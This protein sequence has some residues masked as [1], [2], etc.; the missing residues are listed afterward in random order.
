MT[1]EDCARLVGEVAEDIKTRAQIRELKQR[2]RT[3]T[4]SDAFERAI[5]LRVAR[6]NWA[7]IDILPVAEAVR[8]ALRR[9]F[10]ALQ[11]SRPNF[12]IN[13]NTYNFVIA[14]KMVT[15]RRFPC[16][17][18]DWEISG[19][20]LSWMPRLPK[21]DVP[22]CLSYLAFRMK[23]R[24]PLFF[25]HVAPPPRSRG[26]VVAREVLKSWYQMAKSLELQPEMRG[27][28]ACAW[29]LDPLALRDHPHLESLS[30]PFTSFGGFLSRTSPVEAGSG[31]LERNPDRASRF[32]AGKLDYRMGLGIWSREAAIEWAAGHPELA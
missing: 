24:K 18:M 16:G 27:I 5:L 25:M 31:V 30:Q 1:A 20:P 17:P 9:E 4:S 32:Q 6:A 3:E 10:T 13:V 28:A 19:I 21:K 22:A 12:L 11:N 23:G 15:L 29:F 2:F 7:A 14:A 8:T 26:L